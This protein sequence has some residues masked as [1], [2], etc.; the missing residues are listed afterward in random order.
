[1]RHRQRTRMTT[2]DQNT[3]VQENKPSDKE[4]NFRKQE[5]MFQRM[6]A[7]KESKLA[8]MQKQLEQS[9]TASQDDDDKDD[10]PY[11]DHRK[12]NKT[13]S[14][15]GQSTQ[16]DIQRAMETA[17]NAA[18]EELKQE[19]WLEN[20]PDFYDVLQHAE[21]LALRSP[22]LAESILK[23]PDNFDRQKLVYQNIKELGVDK[24]EQKQSTIQEKIDSNKRSPYY[25]P[26]GIGTAPYSS[27]SDFSQSGQK[28]AYE[29]MQQLK[30]SLRI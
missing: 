22:K 17:K 19:L 16:S 18:K 12:L 28:Q 21:K 7:E 8:E 23:M 11:V 3:Q 10:E 30:K 25:Q 2:P 5:Q 14:K 6:L 9:K 15:F 24:P 13:L 20:N 29:K 26:T 1:M 27:Q 4:L